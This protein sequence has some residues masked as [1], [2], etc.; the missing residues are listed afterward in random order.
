MSMLNKS[1][2]CKRKENWM[3]MEEFGPNRKMLQQI[4]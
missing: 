1:K 2:E 3:E 4:Q